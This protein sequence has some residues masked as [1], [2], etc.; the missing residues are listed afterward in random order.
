[1]HLLL[2]HQNFP[3][4][5]RDLAPAWLTAG[6]EVSAIG[7]AAPPTGPAWDGLTFHQYRFNGI[8]RPTLLERSNAVAQLCLQLQDQGIWPDLVVAHSGWGESLQLRRIWGTTPLVV[9][10]ELWGQASALGFGFDAA[11]DGLSMDGDPFALPNLVGDLAIVQADAAVV[12]STS[13]RDSFPSALQ[14]QLTLLPEGLDLTRLGPDP[15]AMVELPD[16]TLQAGQPIVTLISRLLEPLRGL[17]QALQ[18]WPAVSAAHPKAQLLL[19]GDEHGSGY[20]VEQ[21]QLDSHLQD[22]IASWG[23][24]VDRSRVHV[25][26][27]L[28]HATMLRLLQ[29]SACH[30]A[31]SYPYTLSWSVLEAMACA[32]PLISNHG[33][34]IAPELN[35]NRNGLL[36]PF[37]DGAALSQAI[38]NLLN[39]PE[40]RQRLGTAA[41]CT[42][43]ERFNLSRSLE[44]YEALFQ[45]LRRD[46]P[47]DATA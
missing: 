29:C 17:R 1:M 15:Q 9:M 30:L 36:V 33:S 25:V 40:L 28:E 3:G 44:Q 19:V 20:G 34:P 24:G 35:H 27:W 16:V 31:L 32:A 41:R 14:G 45:R 39:N 21:P 42:I 38:L 26:G 7:C 2:I 10:P 11:L 46:N 22:A 37:N 4:Q 6:H 12:A 8:E 13:Q 47:E 43:Q 23:H 18:A 5:F